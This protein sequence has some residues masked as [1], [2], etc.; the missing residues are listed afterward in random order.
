MCLGLLNHPI[1]INPLDF[2]CY[3]IP[4]DTTEDL[5]EIIKLH[6]REIKTNVEHKTTYKII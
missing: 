2:D 1:Y 5:L 4:I 6:C 3:A